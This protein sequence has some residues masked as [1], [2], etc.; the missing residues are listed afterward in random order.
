MKSYNIHDELHQWMLE[1]QETNGEPPTLREVAEAHESMN[2]RSSARH[3][4]HSLIFR[5]LAAIVEDEGYARRYLAI[6]P[7]K[8]VACG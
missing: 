7:E 2:H 4:L 5:G 8:E 6:L 1:Y 3:T